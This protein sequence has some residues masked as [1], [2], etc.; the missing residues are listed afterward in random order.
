MSNAVRL[1]PAA[2]L[3]IRNPQREH[4]HLPPEGDVVVLDDYFIRLLRTGDVERVPDPAPAP[5]TA[6]APAKSK[7]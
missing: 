2:G 5:V 6:P 3:K 7:K 4:T 1:K